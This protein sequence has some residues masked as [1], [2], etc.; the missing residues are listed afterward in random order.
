MKALIQLIKGRQFRKEDDPTALIRQNIRK[1]CDNIYEGIDF[2][3]LHT[4]LLDAARRG[5]SSGRI[6]VEKHKVLS[7]AAK[8]DVY[9][10]RDS[11]KSS[12]W[13]GIVILDEQGDPWLVYC[14]SHDD[15]HADANM[16]QFIRKEN[17][18]AYMPTDDDYL[19]RDREEAGRQFDMFETGTARTLV[20]SICDVVRS[21]TTVDSDSARRT[22][23]GLDANA[24]IFVSVESDENGGHDYYVQVTFDFSED[25]MRK[26]GF[27]HYAHSLIRCMAVIADP[28][29][30]KPVEPLVDT[31]VDEYGVKRKT[32]RSCMLL[33]DEDIRRIEDPRFAD[34]PELAQ[35][36]LASPPPE[37]KLHQV[38]KRLLSD[39]LI[40]GKPIRSLCGKWFVP[41]LDDSS[42]VPRCE[43]CERTL[44]LRERILGA[45]RPA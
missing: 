38:P 6:T 42:D 28:T 40:Q 22:V 29:E 43:E 17:A 14:G 39:A 7:G 9:E 25:E 35:R 23:S 18:D 8:R 13:R 26:R 24:S 32:I 20:Q 21:C 44:R 30:D 1:D 34:D 37:P 19:L 2:D 45:S 15:F 5:F 41:V 3:A 11:N 4:T 10:I 12:A 16:R 36:L 33:N 31:H 27:D